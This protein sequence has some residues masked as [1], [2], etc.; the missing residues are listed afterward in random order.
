MFGQIALHGIEME[1]ETY[2]VIAAR[3]GNQIQDLS[4]QLSVIED[5]EEAKDEALTQTIEIQAK[6]K[7]AFDNKILESHRIEEE[8]LVL[9]YDNRHKEFPSKLYTRW[10]GPCKVT[11]IYPN[12]SL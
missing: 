11:K 12:G 6:K 8:G 2:R 3:T 9:L 4:T 7:K 10:M 1:V 5:L